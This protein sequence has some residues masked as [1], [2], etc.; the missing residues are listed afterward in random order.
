MRNIQKKK[1]GFGLRIGTVEGKNGVQYLF[2]K[3]PQG[4][5]HAF[6]EVPTNNALKECGS[7]PEEGNVRQ[8]ARRLLGF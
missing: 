8:R 2:F 1:K 5:Y 3:T 6:Q 4:A 7:P